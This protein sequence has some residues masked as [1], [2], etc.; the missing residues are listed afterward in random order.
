MKKK[1]SYLCIWTMFAAS[2]C[3]PLVESEA[4]DQFLEGQTGSTQ[5]T[6]NS[7]D[8]EEGSTSPEDLED[9]STD[10]DNQD[11]EV[12]LEEG[13]EGSDSDADLDTDSD[14]V[15]NS[16]VETLEVDEAVSEEE[17]LSLDADFEEVKK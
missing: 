3:G 12:D 1:I 10:E 8:E 2:A 16:D 5:E 11:S 6:T 15:P 17:R 13:T 4:L 9:T 14:S 7:T